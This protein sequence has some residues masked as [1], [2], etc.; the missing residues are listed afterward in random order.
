MT[1]LRV[2]QKM[3]YILLISLPFITVVLGC[4]SLEHSNEVKSADSKSKDL[5]VPSY[6]LSEIEEGK[7]R[8]ERYFPCSKFPK[9]GDFD[10]LYMVGPWYSKHI[11]ALGE[12]PLW[13]RKISDPQ[14]A[15][16]FTW[17]RS[18]HHPIS[19]RI[20]LL[21]NGTGNVTFSES[22][23]AG[24]YEP[25]EVIIRRTDKLDK[26]NIEK[27]VYLISEKDFFSLETRDYERGLDG[28]EWIFEGLTSEDYNI[29]IRWS[30]AKGYF[31]K[32][33]LLFLEL[34]GYSGSE[35]Y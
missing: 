35:I 32:L 13:N 17:L 11:E 14:Q 24:G 19:V 12:A 34:S 29:V 21:D 16:R 15:Y 26:Q 27:L 18:F 6:I 30:P 10:E 25:G 23:G 28:A 1:T 3:K 8:A 31:Y 4:I 2:L 9:D 33:G 20:E 5:T 7:K 22:D